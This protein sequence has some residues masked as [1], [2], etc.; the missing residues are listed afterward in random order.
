[1]LYPDLFKKHFPSLRGKDWLRSLPPEDRKV[2]G[3]MGCEAN[4]HGRLGGKARV[5]SA[6]RDERGRFAKG[7]K[8]GPDHQRA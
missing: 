7:T 3:W 1:M 8:H 2:F 4:Q 5:A 6:K